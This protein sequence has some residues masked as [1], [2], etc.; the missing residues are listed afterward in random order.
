MAS[1]TDHLRIAMNL[2]N[3][4]NPPI[5]RIMREIECAI[6]HY[7]IENPNVEREEDNEEN[8]SNTRTFSSYSTDD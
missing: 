8:N 3:M 1:I 2:L 5:H 6:S 4:E 7:Y